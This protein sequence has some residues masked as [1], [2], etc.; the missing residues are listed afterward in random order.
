MPVCLAGLHLT[1]GTPGRN[2]FSDL[3]QG[4]GVFKCLS[5]N[6]VMLSISNKISMEVIYSGTSTVLLSNQQ[7]HTILMGPVEL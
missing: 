1:E 6:W 3:C 2:V 5:L 7:Q 4:V